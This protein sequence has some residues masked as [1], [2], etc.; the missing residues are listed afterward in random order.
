MK[1]IILGIIV[2]FNTHFIQAQL[3]Q[4]YEVNAGYSIFQG[5]YGVRGDFS[6]TLGNYGFLL[7]G[8]AYFSLLDYDR[9]DCYSCKH[10]KFPLNFNIGYSLLNFDK[11]D[12]YDNPYPPNVKIR[13]FRGKL[14][15]TSI[16]FGFEYH[17]GDLIRISSKNDNFFNK[18]DPYFGLSGGI[19]AYVIKLSSELGDF[20]V[21]PSILP[22][23]FRERVYDKP[24]LVPMLTFETGLRYKVSNRINAVVNGK[25]L[26]FISDKVDGVVPNPELVD[27][28]YNDWQF[29]M[30]IGVV[31][32]LQIGYNLNLK[33]IFPAKHLVL[34]DFCF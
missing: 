26:Y 8:K 29:A 19:S 13:A 30:S 18:V 3:V 25:W 23:P 1:K 14:F 5:D 21:N 34:P 10:I 27:N 31:F 16:S 2:L 11:A 28:L 22:S 7:N 20:D 6:S 4:E 12:Q 32:Q 9:N 17:I 33:K 15:L 24:G